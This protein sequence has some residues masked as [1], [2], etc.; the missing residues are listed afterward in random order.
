MTT[1]TLIPILALTLVSASTPVAGPTAFSGHHV[2][3][4]AFTIAKPDLI[5]AVNAATPPP[6]PSA[7]DQ[8]A[9]KPAVRTPR[10][11]APAV[12]AGPPASPNS[13]IGIIE[14][15][16]ARW[17]VSGSWMVSIARCESGLRTNAYNPQGTVHR[18]VPVPAV[19]VHPQRWD[20]HLLG[21]R[22][23]QHRRQDA[24]PRPGSPVE[25]RLIA[26]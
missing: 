10:A 21:G 7:G 6:A 1:L 19:D 3:V 18:A 22:P 5:D 26:G 23:V 24:R 4:T 11:A 12:V 16:A 25:L 20:R 17:G 8:P 9:P 2:Q 14:A 13:V 15:A